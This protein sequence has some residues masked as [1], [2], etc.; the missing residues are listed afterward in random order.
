[1]PDKKLACRLKRN[2]DAVAAR[3]LNLGIPSFN[4]KRKLWRPEDDR[5]LGTRPDGQVALLLRRTVLS[6]INRRRK[7]GIRARPAKYFQPWTQTE[8]RLLGSRTDAELARALRRSLQSVRKRRA[9]LGVHAVVFG[10]AW[11]PRELNLLGTNDRSG[12]GATA[13]SQLCRGANPPRE[14]WT[15]TAKSE[16]ETLDRNGNGAFGKIQRCASSRLLWPFSRLR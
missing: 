10:R 4:P 8:D 12:V 3:K 6:I 2:Y 9:K 15:S 11:T 1:M 7:L 16:L 13:R 5:V 14:A